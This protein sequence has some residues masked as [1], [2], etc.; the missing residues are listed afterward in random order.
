MTATK[1]RPKNDGQRGLVEM[2][3]EEYQAVLAD[4][5]EAAEHTATTGWQR[6]YEERRR[7]DERQ[8]RE[9]ANL[10]RELAS[11]IEERHLTEDE[12]KEIGEAKKLVLELQKS[13]EHFQFQTVGPVRKP[14]SEC[15]RVIDQYRSKASTQQALA[16][17]HNTALVG[18]MK[19]EIESH[20]KARWDP[21]AGVVTVE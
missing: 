11:M 14:V 6:L 2:F 21:V 17:L 10:L 9:I 7:E 4:A 18:E 1:T 16:P 5:H 13:R 3:R 15:E 19:R 8:R 12:T 20:Q